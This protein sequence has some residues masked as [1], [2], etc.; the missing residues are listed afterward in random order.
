MAHKVT[1]SIPWRELGKADVEFKVSKDGTTFG[2]LKISK[3]SVVWRP[4][5]HTYGY[6]MPWGKLADL[7]MERGERE[8]P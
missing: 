8:S 2:S 3:G 7:L 4:K 5:D 6:K 1:F